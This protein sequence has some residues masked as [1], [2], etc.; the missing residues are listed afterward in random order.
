MRDM[1]QTKQ[2]QDNVASVSAT[3]C[4]FITR[5]KGQQGEDLLIPIE[6]KYTLTWYNEATPN[7]RHTEEVEIVRGGGQRDSPLSPQDP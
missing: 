5:W 4:P 6:G 2:L 1:E 7:E 3:R